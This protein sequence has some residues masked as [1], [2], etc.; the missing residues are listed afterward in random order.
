MIATALIFGGLVFAS[1]AE[2]MPKVTVDGPRA[3]AVVTVDYAC[4]RGRHVTRWGCR[5]NGWGPARR[6]YGRGYYDGPRRGWYGHRPWRGD[7]HD[8]R[9]YDRRW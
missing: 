2:A 9:R 1:S 7:W 6:V 8:H 5:P 4:G 3:T